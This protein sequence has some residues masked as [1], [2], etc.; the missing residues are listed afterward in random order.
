MWDAGREDPDDAT[1]RWR[2]AA[3]VAVQRGS[4]RDWWWAVN[5]VRKVLGVWPYVNGQLLLR[6]VDAATMTFPSWLDAA[7]MLLWTNTD[8]EGRMRLDLELSMRP[9]GVAVKMSQ[10]QKHKMMEAFAAD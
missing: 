7:F 9:Q 5:L 4:G 1:R 6:S 8:E 3:R 2:N 10:A